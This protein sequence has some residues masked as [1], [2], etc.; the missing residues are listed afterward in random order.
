[1]S[2]LWLMVLPVAGYAWHAVAGILRVI[3]KSNDD[4]GFF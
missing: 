1:M 3:P 2:A 4:F